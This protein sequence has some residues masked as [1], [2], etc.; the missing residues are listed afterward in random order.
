MD[1]T[2]FA[3]LGRSERGRPLTW[4]LGS[5]PLT[6]NPTCRRRPSATPCKKGGFHQG[7]VDDLPP[8][9]RERYEHSSRRSQVLVKWL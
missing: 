9:R 5:N 1:P 8:E 4:S 6:D 2:P 3:P 7:T